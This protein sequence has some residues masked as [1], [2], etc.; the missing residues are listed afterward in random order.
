MCWSDD[1]PLLSC[2][3]T[4]LL[5]PF[6]RSTIP[7][8][9]PTKIPYKLTS[10]YCR[11]WPER[12]TRTSKDDLT[13]RSG[14]FDKFL[15]SSITFSARSRSRSTRNQDPIPPFFLSLIISLLRSDAPSSRSYNGVEG[16]AKEG[17]RDGEVYFC[18]GRVGGTEGVEDVGGADPVQGE[19]VREEDYTDL[20][21]SGEGHCVL[22]RWEREDGGLSVTLCR[23]DFDSA[24]NHADHLHLAL[25][26]PL[27]LR[28]FKCIC[29]LL[30]KMLKIRMMTI[31][32]RL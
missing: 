9:R 29:K 18:R 19:A 13:I 22:R 14:G 25:I 28:H 27:H 5:S 2:K 15:S 30:G 11:L 7:Y 24:M 6:D 10:Q 17:E 12:Q 4:C 23:L 16:I 1:L 32:I 3:P 26:L 31:C 20:E 21:V 8:E